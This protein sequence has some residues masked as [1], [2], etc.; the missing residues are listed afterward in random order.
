LE[1]IFLQ[2]V[3]FDRP[4]M[5][6]YFKILFPLLGFL[7]LFAFV[8]IQSLWAAEGEK[9]DPAL[10]AKGQKL[11]KADCVICHGPRGDGKGSSA[12]L[13]NP[14]PRNFLKDK[15]KFGESLEQIQKTI[16]D[17]VPNSAMPSW[18]ESLGEPDLQALAAYIKSLRLGVA[19]S[20]PEK[21]AKTGKTKSVQ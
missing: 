12:I 10:A 9:P 11:F 2:T 17:G 7:S 14:K 5:A 3:D 15:F 6:G 1:G 13:L 19:V 4:P 18:K 8:L 20:S 21:K 16:G